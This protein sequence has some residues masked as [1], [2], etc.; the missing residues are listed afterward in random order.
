M[1]LQNESLFSS[2]LVFVRFGGHVQNSIV[3]PI[4]KSMA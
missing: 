1:S 4:Y 3:Y 2:E